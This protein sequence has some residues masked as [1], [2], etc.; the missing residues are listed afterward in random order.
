MERHAFDDKKE[1]LK[2]PLLGLILPA[3]ALKFRYRRAEYRTTFTGDSRRV[4]CSNRCPY[5]FLNQTNP[6]G[7]RFES[8]LANDFSR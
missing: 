7:V 6:G 4:L 8:T 2:M 5:V 3:D 1:R